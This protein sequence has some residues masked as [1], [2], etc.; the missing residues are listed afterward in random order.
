MKSP[1][2]EIIEKALEEVITPH[3]FDAISYQLV[4]NIKNEFEFLL[5]EKLYSNEINPRIKFHIK[6]DNKM[7][8]D[9]SYKIVVSFSYQYESP[10]NFSDLNI[11]FNTTNGEVCAYW[12]NCE[13]K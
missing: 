9:G 3:M 11:L 1:D 13:E 10:V 4:Y 5:I 7:D 6:L 8:K 12:T 2:K